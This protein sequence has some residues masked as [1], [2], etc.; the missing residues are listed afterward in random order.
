MTAQGAQQ[1]RL[2]LTLAGY[3]RPRE[4]ENAD[5][6]KMASLGEAMLSDLRRLVRIDPTF[7][8]RA[9]TH[10]AQSILLPGAE[11]DG[12]FDDVGAYV[13][14]PVR[15]TVYWADPDW[16]DVAIE[17]VVK[18]CKGIKVSA[19]LGYHNTVRYVTRHM[20]DPD[21]LPTAQVPAVFVL[22]ELGATEDLVYIDE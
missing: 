18:A 3:V 19:G 13:R 20:T 22:R 6:V 11:N 7:G 14:Q 16:I 9:T 17:A 21:E 5:T 15:L 4:N 1:S 8:G 2:T 12:S 10:I